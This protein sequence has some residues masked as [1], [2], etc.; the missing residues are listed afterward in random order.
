MQTIKLDF[1]QR[2]KLTNLLSSQ[3]GTLGKT[4]PFLRMLEKVRFTDAEEA[5]IIK[6]PMSA[7]LTNYAQPS[8]GFG[9]LTVELET[10]EAAVLVVL[11]ESWPHFTPSDHEWAQRLLKALGS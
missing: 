11:M 7:G 10:S 2:L 6:T 3:E 5:Q 1:V 8:A 9:Q 4:A